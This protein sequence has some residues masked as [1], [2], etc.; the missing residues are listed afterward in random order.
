MQDPGLF[1][2]QDSYGLP[3]RTGFQPVGHSKG[4]EAPKLSQRAGTVNAHGRLAAVSEDWV[5]EVNLNKM[6]SVYGG[7]GVWGR[8]KIHFQGIG[9]LEIRC[10]PDFHF[11]LPVP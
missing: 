2:N 1:S 4:I 11:G 8:Q 7:Y 9:R 6:G 3:E 5:G 10:F